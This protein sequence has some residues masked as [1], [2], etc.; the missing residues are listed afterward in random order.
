[1]AGSHGLQEAHPAVPT[2]SHRRLWVPQRWVRCPWAAK[3][4]PPM[5][6][7]GQRSVDEEQ[8]VRLFVCRREKQ[9]GRQQSWLVPVLSL[10]YRAGKASRGFLS[11]DPL[12]ES[13][14]PCPIPS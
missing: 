7:L 12:G 5:I 11:P 10:L 2:A 1:M 6:S 3:H 14:L 8:E 9:T 13:Q 4:L